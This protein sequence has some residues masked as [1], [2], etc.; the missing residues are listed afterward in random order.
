MQAQL[1]GAT[2]D[3]SSGSLV[4]TSNR[5]GEVSAI[6]VDDGTGSPAALLGLSTTLVTGVSSPATAATALNDLA[7]NVVDYQNG[8]RID[9]A[10]T[11]AAGQALPGPSS[12]AP[13][14]PRSATCATSST[15]W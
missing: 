3:G 7:D 13:T 14:A 1:T 15:T 2:V 4:I 8:D 10:G 11:N 9:V 5:T 12:T 6:K